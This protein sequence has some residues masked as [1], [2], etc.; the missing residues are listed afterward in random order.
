MYCMPQ[1]SKGPCLRCVPQ[2]SCPSTYNPCLCFIRAFLEHASH[3]QTLLTYCLVNNYLYKFLLLNLLM[4][5]SRCIHPEIIPSEA[6]RSCGENGTLC[7]TPIITLTIITHHSTSCQDDHL[8]FIIKLVLLPFNS[9]FDNHISGVMGP[10]PGV[11]GTLQ[12]VE[13]LKVS[14]P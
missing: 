4:R 14:C 6:S 11:I 13:T 1:P 2:C 5:C 12:A 8:M 10:V 7:L 9:H 3:P